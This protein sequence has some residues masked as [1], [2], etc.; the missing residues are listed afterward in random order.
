MKSVKLLLLVVFCTG[1]VP[2]YAQ[3]GVFS[4]HAGYLNPKDTKGGLMIGG[5][6]G[7]AIDE[8]VEIGVG[9]DV[10]HKSY[11]DFSTVS[12]VD[13]TGLSSEIEETEVD[14][15]RT[16]IPLL[17]CIV[18][19]SM[20]QLTHFSNLQAEDQQVDLTDQLRTGSTAPFHRIP[21]PTMPISPPEPEGGVPYF[22]RLLLLWDDA[23][24][25]AHPPG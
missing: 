14:Y 10:F 22:Q 1:M 3:Q 16:I 15:G 12:Q 8:A 20:P 4:I 13:Q 5:M 19:V 9:L 2:V 24:P 11:S 25:T 6:L 18:K 17:C 23:I 21:G 7:K